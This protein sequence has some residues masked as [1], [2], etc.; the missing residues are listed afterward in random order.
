M[1]GPTGIQRETVPNGRAGEKRTKKT[2][3]LSCFSDVVW[4]GGDFLGG[5]GFEPTKIRNKAKK[6]SWINHMP[7]NLEEHITLHKDSRLTPQTLSFFQIM[8]IMILEK[9]NNPSVE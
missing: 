2:T 8:Y 7:A 4:G 6:E 3:C 1:P 9:K 5:S